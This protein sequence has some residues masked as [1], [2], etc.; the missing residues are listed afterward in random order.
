MSYLSGD[1]S[2]NLAAN[3][4][5]RV[6]LAPTVTTYYQKRKG[7]IGSLTKYISRL[8]VMIDRKEPITN[9]KTIEDKI[10]Y[11]MFKINQLTEN[12]CLALLDN[13]NE[14]IKAQELCSEHL[15]RGNKALSESHIYTQ[16][17]LKAN[18][19][20]DELNL[21]KSL[22][23]INKFLPKHSPPSVSSKSSRSSKSK[24]SSSSSS[25]SRKELAKAELLADQEKRK[26]ERKLQKLKIQEEQFRLQQEL[27][28]TE[29][30][31]QLEDAEHKL[32]IAKI[33][34]EIDDNE[35]SD[36]SSIDEYNID[37]RTKI[38]RDSPYI[39]KENNSQV[40]NTN[41][42]PVYTPVNKY[43]NITNEQN[44]QNITLSHTNQDISDEL[45]N[46]NKQHTIN[47]TETVNHKSVDYFIDELVEGKETII[48][49]DFCKHFD[50]LTF[51]KAEYESR[52]LPPIELY[53]F[54]G[55]PSK[56]PDFIENFSKHVHFKTTFSDNQ[57]MERL[58]NVLDGEAKRMV[59][60]I[61][62][63]GIF[64]ATVL[65]CL[66]RDYGNPTVVSYL[67]LKTL[68]DAPQ[69]QPQNKPAIRSFQQ[70]LKTTV[71]WLSSMGYH[72]AIKSIDNITK[73]VTRLPNYLR[74]KFYKEFSNTDIDEN[75]VDLIKFS[76][77]LDQKLCEVHNPIASIINAEEKLKRNNDKSQKAREGS[78]LNGL[79]NNNK[80]DK[81]DQENFTLICWLCS[82]SHKVSD[83]EKLK[84][85]SIENRRNLV[86]QKKLCFNCL[87]NTHMITKCKS[88]KHCQIKN[89]QRRHH[90]LL[91][92]EQKPP[93]DDPNK[94]DGSVNNL[95]EN[96]TS[97]PTHLQIVPVT[98]KNTKGDIEV[99]TN[100]MLD[101]GSDTSLIR[102][103]IA[104]KLNLSG[105]KTTMNLSNVVSKTKKVSS[106]IVSF[107]ILP[108]IENCNYF[109]IDHAIVMNTLNIPHNK[110][111]NVVKNNYKHLHDISFPTLYQSDVTVLIGA[112][113]PELHL[114]QE[115]KTG[116]PG[117]PVAVKTKLGWM[118]MG[119]KRKENNINCNHL[120]K[121][122]ISEN[123]ERFWEIDTYGTL[124]KLNKN[125]LPPDQKRALEILENTTVIKNNQFE[126]GMLWKKD[127]PTLPFNRELAKKR[128]LSLEKKFERNQHFKELYDY[129]IND[130]I[131]KGYAK[132]LTQEELLKTSTVTNYLPHHGVL[133]PQKPNKV[134]VVFDAA[135]KYKE[136]SLNNNLLSGIDLLNNLVSVL[137][138]FRRGK[139]AV[140]SDIEAM[141]HQ[142]QVPNPETDAL[143]FLWR[144]NIEK[145]IEDY[146]M[147]VHIFGK[148][149][150]PCIA[151]WALKRTAPDND[152]QLKRI[153]EDEFYRD[154]FLYSLN[155]KSELN[156]ICIKLIDVLS[157]YGFNL[158]KWKASDPDI[159][160]NIPKEKLV[161]QNIKLDLNSDIK[162][163]ALG[164]LW[165]VKNDQLTFQH[166]PKTLPN[167]K[168]GI[169]S[170]VASVFDPLGI[171]TPGI[172]EAKL[173]IQSLWKMKVDWDDKI[174]NDILNRYQQWLKELCHIKEIYISRWFNIDIEK[175]SDI[176][177]HI[178]SDA[179]NSAYGAVAYLK[180]I[181]SNKSVFLMSKSRLA[182]I[183]E[184]TLT[185][186]RLELQAA[187][188]AVRLKDTI[189]EI[190]NIQFVRVM[191]WV[192]SQIVLNYIKNTSRKFPTF[193][194]N[195]LN[196]IRLN[197]NISDWNFISGNQNPADLCTRYTPFSI[198]KSNKTWFYGPE[199]DN[200]VI[201]NDETEN[202]ITDTE[203]DHSSVN[204]TNLKS[205]DNKELFNWEHYS[206]YT[207]LLRH[208]AWVIKIVKNW[209]HIKRKDNYTETKQLSPEDIIAA[210]NL[211]VYTAQNETYKT[212]IDILK[213]NKELPKNNSIIS[214]RPIIQNNLL[215]VGGRLR[216][217]TIPFEAKHQLLLHKDHPLS[218]LLF[219]HYHEKVCHSGR[220]QTLAET[221]EKFW[222][223]KGR[224]LL[225][226]VLTEC[227]YC[228]RQRAKPMAPLMGDLPEDRIEI[229]KP[230][231]YNSGIDYF[232][233]ILTKQSKKTRSTTGKTKR[234]GALFTCLNTRALHLELVTDLTTDAFI[235]ALRRFCSRRGYPS[236][237]RSDNGKN[238][239]GAEREL[240]IAL[241]NLDVKK[242]EE[243]LNQNQTKWI[244]NP[245]CSP[246]MSG[247][248]ESMVKVTKRALKA[249]IKDRT[250]TDESLYTVMT[251]V[252]SI[253]NSR[254]LTS[255]SDSIDDYEALTP[256]HF[257]LG[258]RSNNVPIINNEEVDV[259]L[260]SKWKSVQ[261][262]T[263]MFWSRWLREYLPTITKRKKWSSL[264][265][266]MSK[267]D[268]VLLCDKNV[269]RSQWQ[270]GRIIET[271]PGPD[272][273]VRVVKVRTKD[274]NYIRAVAS[275]A[276]LECCE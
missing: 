41:A 3:I 274:G 10:E 242:I 185:T 222:I 270:L 20:Q 34:D 86:K 35:S 96:K 48:S 89:C 257:L 196:E 254:P 7:H 82:G 13:E 223:V 50:A 275:L 130:Y 120:S 128:F 209:V 45:D 68:F 236:I 1:N 216:K 31:E 97:C 172:L 226:K 150:S 181:S 131:E 220:E 114:H 102:K 234:W 74:N 142:V 212:E 115:F 219:H 159:L 238:F 55:D 133:H 4:D 232:G 243:E 186:P 46:S 76:N 177:L 15:N 154:D 129:Q 92:I 156:K 179:S 98:L 61:G 108:E 125:I 229:G 88:K 157:I 29:V 126:V 56:W 149:D 22:Q 12:I 188:T 44:N 165:D 51:L 147:Q 268:L 83:C 28:K 79:H 77:W 75:K 264:S 245:P 2:Q 218:R 90:T 215:K 187:V 259:T 203:E 127:D 105:V 80:D 246:W 141:F 104:E 138:R 124:P 148:T 194:M 72:S 225:K 214:F 49:T 183:K 57:R 164:L 66:K 231:F 197:S 101:S 170:L 58:L 42:N 140:I 84:N 143:R 24:S 53:K 38:R 267:G 207:K 256:N 65:K 39:P 63:S 69:L 71:I 176:E 52:N 273:I 16:N 40:L 93:P 9:I 5:E 204:F 60:S 269:K 167:T 261:A 36:I 252:E 263:N 19:E 145:E 168:R 230:P 265:R 258:R 247:A 272:D 8:S 248:M 17:K 190:F 151:D 113:H 37:S 262:A 198:L 201:P 244:F 276:L 266:N 64:Y 210:E 6:D 175:K 192:D 116:N 153:I 118:L 95:T 235:L 110:I 87:S 155:C 178:Y 208:V 253:V 174:P 180:S 47:L 224:G 91:H 217:S 227:L 121:N 158:T 233:P 240:K 237:I 182:P 67:K 73:A 123:L 239:V 135:A 117:D 195:R 43:R 251:E 26:A 103:D 106:E 191:F 255:V 137:C 62:Q 25:S 94:I 21:N 163:R 78:R 70:Q 205:I 171:L 85:E 111:D 221:R 199:I 54:S 213:A 260:R 249:I 169:L 132:K 59:Q 161:N 189:V 119:G 184:K 271:M 33:L 100:A 144:K 166:S 200:L 122:S 228:K 139:Y 112:D 11:T 23:N 18:F 152:Q 99:H 250:F 211:I 14:K 206:S 32:K 193:V 27:E 30:L 146:A 162:E 160:K 241:Q 109:T 173:I 136:N 202:S 81:K 134:R 107:N